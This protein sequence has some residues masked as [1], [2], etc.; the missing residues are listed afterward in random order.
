MRR[1]EGMTEGAARRLLAGILGLAGM[2]IAMGVVAFQPAAGGSIF[3]AGQA[4]QVSTALMSQPIAEPT[5]AV[6]GP[7]A[8]DQQACQPIAVSSLGVSALDGE[9]VTVWSIR[10][11]G[12]GRAMVRLID[13]GGE[14]LPLGTIYLAAQRTLVFAV[15]NAMVHG[16]LSLATPC[17]DGSE[18]VAASVDTY[19]GHAPVL[20]TIH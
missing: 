15:P 8:E 11:T 20:L 9:S 19:R 2:S 7:G 6:I 3:G 5:M 10:N 17:A 1:T 12:D 13:A 4:R 14:N 16:G 18:L